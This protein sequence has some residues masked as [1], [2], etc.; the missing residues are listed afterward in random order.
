[1]IDHV[2]GFDHPP[3]A[4]L[5]F[6]GVEVE[7]EGGKLLVHRFWTYMNEEEFGPARP[8]DAAWG[9]RYFHLHDPDGQELSFAQPIR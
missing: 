6:P 5:F 1:V 2:R 3:T 8:R 9:E 4:R 7:V